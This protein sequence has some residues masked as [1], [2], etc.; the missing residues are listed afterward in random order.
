MDDTFSRIALNLIGPG[1]IAVLGL[2]F[3]WA[4][5][6]ERKRHYLIALTS[7]C[8]L[9]SLAIASQVLA[10][11]KDFGHNAIASNFFYTNAVLTL[12]W[13]LLRR[14]G[15]TPHLGIGLA[16][17]IIS[18]GLI[19]YFYY[20]DQNLTAR[21]YVQNFGFGTILLLT[22]IRLR[23][24]AKG[25]LM[26]QILFWVLL[27]FALHFFPRT[28][29]TVAQ[30]SMHENRAFGLTLFWQVL[31]L[32]LAVLG[33]TLVI[34]MLMAVV[35]DI[36]EDLRRERDTDGLTGLRNR[37]SFDDTMR[38]LPARSSSAKPTL[39]LCDIDHFKRINDL[40]GH[41]AGDTVL[42]AFGSL[43]ADHIRAPDS[44]YR[45]G[46][47]EFAIVVAGG[48]HDARDLVES[49]Q[50][51]FASISFTLPGNM[52][53]TASF[54]GAT[55]HK[56]ESLRAWFDRADSALY[57]SKQQGR[58]R[59]MFEEDHSL[60]VIGESDRHIELSVERA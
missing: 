12:G 44:V 1:I 6:L 60:E 19:W 59:A 7:S 25:K 51:T 39:L 8:L 31:Q 38:A 4:W 3:F 56:D 33:A 26:D 29:L 45:V 13:G 41:G 5:L 55:R 23:E 35:S 24:L 18:S 22:A 15:Q 27:I 58:D 57:A 42:R 43:L 16:I 36:I 14:S 40:H 37:R 10:L 21:I 32:S 50:H 2:G 28:V 49:L 48:M 9:F 53:I 34:A 46:G 54:G 20:A 52:P 11:P 47:E 17:L 30:S